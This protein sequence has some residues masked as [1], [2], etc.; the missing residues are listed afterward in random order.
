[1]NYVQL[2]VVYSSGDMLSEG[3]RYAEA[4]AVQDAVIPQA[5]EPQLPRCLLESMLAG[6][7]ASW[8]SSGGWFLLRE[9][10]D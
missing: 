8:H 9:A 7:P 6:V 10:R 4:K 5:T 1:M 2:L 3:L